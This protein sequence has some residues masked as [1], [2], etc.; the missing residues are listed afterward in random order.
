MARIK[1]SIRFDSSRCDGRHACLRVCPTEAIRIRDGKAVMLSEHCVD[2][3][4]C[5]RA[6]PNNAIVPLTNSFV[7]FSKFKHN[8]ALPSP[9]FYTQFGKHASPAVLLEALLEIGFDSYYDVSATCEA[10]SIAVDQFLKDYSGPAP[11]I[12]PYCPTVLR[13]LQKRFPD[14]A[15]HL[16]P[17]DSPMEIAARDAKEKVAEATGLGFDDIGAIY[18]TPCPVKML[19]IHNHPRKSRSNLDGAI[20]ISDI[21]GPVRSALGKISE[22]KEEIEARVKNISGIGVGWSRLDGLTRSIRHETLVV[23]VMDFI[24]RTFEEIESGKLRDIK[25]VECYACRIGCAGGILNVE[26]PYVSRHR[27]RELQAKLGREATLDREEI[28]AKF[29]KGYFNVEQEL[30]TKPLK[31][32]DE[33]LSK[34]IEKMNRREELLAKLP[35]INCGVCGAPTCETFAEDVVLGRAEF[36]QCFAVQRDELKRMLRQSLDIVERRRQ[37]N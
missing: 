36:S 10:T 9:V 11:L 31:P 23:S 2:C 15:N 14:L 34:A 22:R 24:I 20:A 30:A 4:E 12:T 19:A 3:G 33:D 32:L 1:H 17:L 28:I 8:I 26:N 7:E 5:L 37:E 27:L 6:C 18:L 16:L 29:E 21:Y 25:L 35:R 13:L